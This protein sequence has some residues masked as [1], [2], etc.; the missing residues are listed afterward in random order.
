MKYY[1]LKLV[2]CSYVAL[3]V[4]IRTEYEIINEFLAR[5]I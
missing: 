4:C 3:N 5:L 1:I 2:G